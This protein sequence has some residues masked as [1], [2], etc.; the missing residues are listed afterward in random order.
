MLRHTFR[1]LFIPA[2]ALLLTVMLYNWVN[3]TFLE[4]AATTST[5]ST[6]TGEAS[7]GGTFN[8][9]NQDGK[10][11][12]D[13]NFKGKMMIV[14]FGFTH[15]PDVCPAGMSL[16]TQAMENLGADADKVQPVFITIDPERD[17][18]EQMKTY[19][20]NFYPTFQ[21]LTGTPEQIAGVINSYKIYAKKV[22]SKDLSEYTMDHSAYIYLM[23]RDGKYITHFR[24]D[25]KAEEIA[26]TVK[27]YLH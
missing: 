6:K 17:N 22:E 15:C 13:E 11:V 10:Q 24:G 16:I 8:L 18:V 25:Q 2:I 4:G 19:V 26:A 27:K 3:K 1:Y 20:S 21:A 14:Y 12:S 9:T 23:G 7:I 5:Q